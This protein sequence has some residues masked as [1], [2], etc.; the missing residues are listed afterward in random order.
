MTVVRA[1]SL[2]AVDQETVE[3]DARVLLLANTRHDF[4]NRARYWRGDGD[5]QLFFKTDSRN[6]VVGTGPPKN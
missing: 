2:P 3:N 6:N 4:H 5:A 1:R